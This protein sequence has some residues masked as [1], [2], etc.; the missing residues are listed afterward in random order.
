MDTNMIIANNISMA[1]KEINKKQTELADALGISKQIVNKMLMGARTINA[2][3]LKK[4]ADFCNK[5]MD[6][7]LRIESEDI[8]EDN[9]HT[10]MGA[11]KTKNA[12]I[13]IEIADELIEMY[14]FHS[15]VYYNSMSAI[16][17][18]SDL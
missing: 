4:I 8:F 16:N 2:I 9:I 14:L 5:S 15:N 17:D 18:W 11:A 10:F 12:K 1:L 3:E 6:D 13:G 7:L